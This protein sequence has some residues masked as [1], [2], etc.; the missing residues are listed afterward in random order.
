MSLADALTVPNLDLRLATGERLD[1]REFT[2]VEEL[3]QPFD[4]RLIA[5]SPNPEIDFDGA[6]GQAARFE[7]RRSTLDGGAPRAWGGVCASMALE[8]V[9]E[10]GLSTYSVRLVPQLW[11]LSQRRNYRVFQDLSEL[12]VVLEVLGSWGIQPTLELQ[13]ASYR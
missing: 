4:V 11:L 9:E 6:I 12:D 5:M 8:K 2:I 10:E 7:L 1:V 3:S 13:A